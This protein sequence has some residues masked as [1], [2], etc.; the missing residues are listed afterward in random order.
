AKVY[1]ISP[2]Q[3]QILL[4]VS[5]HRAALCN[6]THLAQE[7]NVT[8]PTVSD[9][10]KVLHQK[11]YLEKDH[12]S[13][14]SRSYILFVTEA[15]TELINQIAGY[16][17]PVENELKQFDEQQLDPLYRSI[18]DLIYQLNQQGVLQVQRTCF[19]CRFYEKQSDH[20]YCN[21]LKTPLKTTD[22]RLDCPEYEKND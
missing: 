13:T 22:I 5:N 20:H 10:V 8:K 2:I 17:Q 19:G 1:G 4:F 3:I 12:S 18:T 9:A 15:G 14:D 16:L 6:V 11:G 21:F 7:F